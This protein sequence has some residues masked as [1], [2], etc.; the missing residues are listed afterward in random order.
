MLLHRS[1]FLLL[2]WCM[3]WF[4]KGSKVPYPTGAIV[5]TYCLMLVRTLPWH[6]PQNTTACVQY[7]LIHRQ[8]IFDTFSKNRS[9]PNSWT[10][11]CSFSL[12]SPL[13]KQIIYLCTGNGT[14]EDLMRNVEDLKNSLPVGKH[15]E[16]STKILIF[17]SKTYLLYTIIRKWFAILFEIC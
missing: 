8:V 15:L 13:L 4:G 10:R 12:I 9:I 1:A 16:P 11:Y 7:H 3:V 6:G 5:F 17:L 2:V 14:S